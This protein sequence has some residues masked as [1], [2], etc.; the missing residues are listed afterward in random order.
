VLVRLHVAGHVT[1]PELYDLPARL[2][3]TQELVGG[4]A[5]VVAISSRRRVS[6]KTP[7]I[8]GASGQS[9]HP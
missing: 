9:Q 3:L 2:L 1:G 4:R 7:I 6:P 8:T 5:I